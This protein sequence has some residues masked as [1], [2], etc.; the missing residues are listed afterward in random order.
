VGTA[1]W[2]G[3]GGVAETVAKATGLKPAEV[4]AA[5]ARDSVTG[6]FTTP[7]E[8]AKAVLFLAGDTAANITGADIRVDGGLVSTW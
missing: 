4:A 5:A 2:L 7:Q 8:V 3:A 1:L 6:R